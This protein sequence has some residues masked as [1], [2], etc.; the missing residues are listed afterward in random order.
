MPKG[1]YSLCLSFC[2]SWFLTS[3]LLREAGY[4]TLG[5]LLFY[6]GYV[7]MPLLKHPKLGEVL[8]GAVSHE[9][10]IAV[11]HEVVKVGSNHLFSSDF[12][13]HAHFLFL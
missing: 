6:S 13:R 9:K 4:Q 8:V 5:L 3:F 2:Q 10:N 7:V 11:R 12:Q 1:F